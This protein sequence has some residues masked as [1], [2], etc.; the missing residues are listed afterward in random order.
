MGKTQHRSRLI[1]IGAISL[2]AALIALVSTGQAHRSGCHRWHSCP[3]DSGS[4]ICGDLGYSTFCPKTE[5]AMPTP[6]PTV[7][8]PPLRP[9][10]VTRGVP[11]IHCYDLRAMGMDIAQQR[12]N[13]FQLG[14]KKLDMRIQ[15]GSKTA[16]LGSRRSR[17]VLKAR[18]VIWQGVLY[19]PA[20]AMKTMGCKVD[21]KYLPSGVLLDC[22]GVRSKVVVFVKIW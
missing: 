9:P 19:V 6:T 20:S 22:S 16:L 2:M 14:I 12:S 7:K 1:L 17:V 3:S 13:W 18:P 5:A 11:Y 15:V 4:Y 10:K 21:S 8:A